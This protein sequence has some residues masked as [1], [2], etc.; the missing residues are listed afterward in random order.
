MKVHEA[1]V[2]GLEDIGVDTAF[3]GAGESISGLM[4]ALKHSDRIRTIITRNEQAASFMACGYAMYSG[5]LGFCFG[6]AG[7]GAFNLFSGLATALA[8]SYPVLAV[9]GYSPRRWR[10]WGALNETSGTNRTPDSQAMFAATTKKSF[11]LGDAS[12]IFD[13]L[14][15]AVGLAF[16]GRPG[17]VHIH[18]P[19]DLGEP[20]MEV[21]GIRPLRLRVS[22]VL[23]DPERVEEIVAVLADAITRRRRVVVLAG[24]GAVR[25]GAGAEVERLI[26]RFQFPLVTTLDGKGIVS[27]GHPLSLGVFADSGHASAWKAFREADVVLCVGNSLNQHATF[28]FREDLFANKLLIHL[29]ISETE[30]QKAYKPDYA[31]LSDARPAVAALVEALERKVGEV[32]RAEV[33]GRDWEARHIPHLTR[34]IHPGEL[35]QTIGRML[36]PR[37]IL[38]ADAGAHAPWLGYYVELEKGQN[39][40]KAD[41]FGAMA[42]HVNGAIGVKLAHPDRAVVVGCGDGCYTMGGFELMTAVEHDIPVIWVVFNDCEFKLIK[43]A[44]LVEYRET[45]FSEFQNPDFAAYARACGADGHSVDTLEDFEDV[46]RRALGSGRPTVIDARITR[47][48]VPHY[49]PSPEGVVAGL[50]ETIE[51]RLRN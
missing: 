40:R 19:G 16:E 20:G 9:S 3:G 15:E 21:N 39:F 1:L 24:Y 25:S 41:S 2:K 5:K 14:E 4:V 44:Q 34:K 48:A 35:A 7:P 42:A 22:P 26:E 29:N 47:W 10:G 36:P 6:S 50:I 28:D 17:P 32:P 51:E 11:L 8:G 27:E 13:V 30:F 18:I 33:A 43:I 12:E 46:F 49:S 38:L 23:P 37:G 31:L 45:A